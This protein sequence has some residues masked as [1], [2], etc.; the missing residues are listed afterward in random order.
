MCRTRSGTRRPGTGRRAHRSR[1]AAR[2][3][4]WRQ[5]WRRR[6]PGH[7]ARRSPAAWRLMA[8]RAWATRTSSG[9]PA[10]G[11]LAMASSVCV[12]QR[13]S[14]MRPTLRMSECAG[15]A[16]PKAYIAGDGRPD[17]VAGVPWDDFQAVLFD[18]DGVLTPTADIHQ[19]AW[20]TM[21]DEF[22]VPPDLR[23]SP[24]PTTSPTSTAARA[25]TACARSSR[26]GASSCRR[27]SPA[28]RRET[29]GRR[30]GQPQGRHVPGGAARRGHRPVPGLRRGCSTSSRRA[31]RRLAV[32]SSSRNAREVLGAGGPGRTVPR[33]RRRHRRRRAGAGRQAGPRHVPRRRPITSGSTRPGRRRRGRRV[34]RGRRAGR[35]LRSRHRRRPGRRPRCA[36]AAGADL[37]VDDLGESSRE[38]TS[39]RRE[40]I[41]APEHLDAAPFPGRSVAAWSSAS[42][43]RRHR[44]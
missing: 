33:R 5:R 9:R 4:R 37:V 27:A 6:H 25:S 29:L 42:P 34:R 41:E 38:P 30:A 16:H 19:P 2:R 39:G 11:K 7:R 22:L 8:A 13:G 43:T 31:A 28:I 23:R 26:P 35:R 21:F 17:P 15:S 24:R 44:R 18:L 40:A 10:I 1:R 32:V 20:T 36:P 3:R 14:V 12:P